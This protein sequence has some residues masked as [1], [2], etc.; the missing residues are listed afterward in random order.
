MHSRALRSS[1]RVLVASNPLHRVSG[2]AK[3]VAKDMPSSC[4]VS[5]HNHAYP[6]PDRYPPKIVKCTYLSLDSSRTK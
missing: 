3:I 1:D 6:V 4:F 2:G 5:E